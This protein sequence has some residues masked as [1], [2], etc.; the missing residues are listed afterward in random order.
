M[1]ARKSSESPGRKKPTI[2]PVSANM[3]TQMPTRPNVLSRP[4]ASS[5]LSE[6]VSLKARDFSAVSTGNQGTGALLRAAGHRLR[7]L[8]RRLHLQEAG[9]V[10]LRLVRRVPTA[11]PEEPLREQDVQYRGD[12][13]DQRTDPDPG[14]LLGQLIDLD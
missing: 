3:I 12:V 9:L 2:R 7:A 11:Y 8:G 5:G 4:L 14:D 10:P 13:D 1:P 6:R